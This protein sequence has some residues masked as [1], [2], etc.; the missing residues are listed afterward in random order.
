VHPLEHRMIP[1]NLTHRGWGEQLRLPFPTVAGTLFSSSFRVSS[2]GSI[3][4]LLPSK[5]T[6]TIRRSTKFFFFPKLPPDA[7]RDASM[8]YFENGRQG[9]ARNRSSRKSPS[10]RIT[11]N[12][13]RRTRDFAE[14]TFKFLVKRAVLSAENHRKQV[15]EWARWPQI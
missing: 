3:C 5:M 12:F 11:S 4:T 14:K 9:H 1:C 6:R 10:F 13:E 7:T 8:K 2:G 15:W